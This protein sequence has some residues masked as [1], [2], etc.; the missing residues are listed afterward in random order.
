MSSQATRS[1]QRL[2]TWLLVVVLAGAALAAA[3][4]SPHT[5]ARFPHQ[6]HLS[7]LDCGQPNQPECLTCKSCHDSG[8]KEFVL[9]ELSTCTQCH[10]ESETKKLATLQAPPPPSGPTARAIRFSHQLHV[11]MKEIKGQCVPCHEVQTDLTRTTPSFPPMSACLECHYHQEQFEQPTCLNCHAQADLTR[12]KPETFIRHD[13]AFMRQHGKQA[14]ML[15]STCAQCH[16]EKECDD[17]HNATAPLSFAQKHPELLQRDS[18][19]IH[20][21]DFLSRHA[22]AARSEPA[23]CLTCHTVPSCD[24]CHVQ[25]GVSGNALNARNPHPPE[26]V[27]GNPA[28]VNFHGRAA[29][30]DLLACAAC[31]DQGPATNCIRCHAVGGH[32]GNPHPRGWR[33]S[34]TPDAEMCRYCHVR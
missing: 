11:G 30:R 10:R 9:P 29:R 5:G 12:L 7:Q 16:A 34:R 22:M 6:L 4:H 31:H 23:R 19:S 14:R 1:T 28:S 8:A 27:G 17:C 32:G 20:P 33:S 18:D 25:R 24:S 3:C 26:W 21:P 2:W 13:G 15:E